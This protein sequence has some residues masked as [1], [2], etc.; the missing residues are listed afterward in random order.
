M[1]LLRKRMTEEAVLRGLRPRTQESYLW[2]V[3][4]LARYYGRSPDRLS[5]D[6]VRQYL[7]HLMTERELASASV[8]VH[9]AGI[10]FFYS[11][12]M[13][14]ERFEVVI[15]P[16]KGRVKLPEVLSMEEVERL[17]NAC[18]NPKYRMALATTYAAGLRVSETVN[19]LL[20]A[21]NGDR[22]MMHVV[23][24]K[25][26]KDR[27]VPLSSELLDELRDYCRIFRPQTWLFPSRDPRQHLSIDALQRA[28]TAAKQAAGLRRGRGPHTLRHSYAT[29]LLEAGVD[30]F[31]IQKLLG[32]AQLSSTMRYAK[33]TR[34][35]IETT[36]SPYD[37]L[38][39]RK[40][41]K[42]KKKRKDGKPRP[43]DKNKDRQ[44]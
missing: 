23:D 21:I 22:M 24:G 11:K 32:H 34:R 17:L 43:D 41:E 31:T 28:F 36:P 4:Q 8:R 2:S 3:E 40:E 20:D 39:R 26:G 19:L 7:V 44:E 9:A 18:E 38:K 16:Y 14:R 42:N 33:V 30:I 25:G 1:S 10:R 27:Y 29:H 37:L 6:E 13:E 5:N 12:V 15:P 35:K